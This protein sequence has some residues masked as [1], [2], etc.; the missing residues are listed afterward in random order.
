MPRAPGNEYVFQ[1]LTAK[2]AKGCVML[3]KGCAV[4]IFFLV[5]GAAHPAQAQG[6]CRFLQSGIASYYSDRFHGRKTASAEKFNKAA[7]TA[8]HRS[9]PFGSRVEVID[10]RSGKK[11]IVRINDRGPFKKGRIIDLSQAA[12]DQLGIGKKGLSPVEI[13]LCK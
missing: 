6:N 11:T 8:A 2:Q 9:L 13:R 12:R 3:R 10:K 5:A 4:L 1:A 7:L